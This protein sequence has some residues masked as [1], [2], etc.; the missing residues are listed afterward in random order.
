MATDD[1]LWRMLE[2]VG[3]SERIRA[4]P[5]GLDENVGDRGSQLSGGERQRLVIVRALLRRPTLLILD[6]ATAALDPDAEAELLGRLKELEP[7]PAALV[8]AHRESTLKHCDS[9]LA[10]QHGAPAR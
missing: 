6:E 9:V 3:L 1:E 2:L 4:L 8:V 5:G 10:I 7:R